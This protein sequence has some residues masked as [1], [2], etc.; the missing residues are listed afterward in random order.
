[1]RHK[2]CDQW[3]RHINTFIVYIKM[4]GYIMNPFID[5]K[6]RCPYP[7]SYPPRPPLS[8]PPP[9]NEGKYSVQNVSR[10]LF[11]SYK[12]RIIVQDYSLL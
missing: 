10:R 4:Y 7:P 12:H 11:S 8:L 3:I 6:E 5:K 9:G 2:T 1:M